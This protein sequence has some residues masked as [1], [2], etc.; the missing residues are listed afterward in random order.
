MNLLKNI[1]VLLITIVF[2]FLIVEGGFKILHIFSDAEVSPTNIKGLPY[3]NTP[4]GWFLRY[5]P[6]SGWVFYKNNSLGMRD[7]EREYDKSYGVKRVVCLGDS[8]MFG[9]EVSF[10][11]MFSRQLEKLLNTEDV[12][13]VEVLNCGTTSYSLREY[14]VYLKEKALKFDPDLIMIGL[15]LNDYVTTFKEDITGNVTGVSVGKKFE[16]GWKLFALKLKRVL[17]YSYFLEYLNNSCKALTPSK[18]E[19]YKQEQFKDVG[20]AIVWERNKK[21]FSQMKDI[22]DAHE[23]PLLV[24]I[25]P[26]AVQLGNYSAEEQPQKVIVSILKS[27]EIDY[28]DLLPVYAVHQQQTG[29]VFSRFDPVHPMPLGH[30][31]AADMVK[32]E[33]QGKNLL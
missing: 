28:V 14:V 12:I 30:K 15:C 11:K 18:K 29:K 20:K 5:Q 23:I 27:L 4:N 8:I 7:V 9:G 16:T 17:F 6:S 10:D 2:L 32:K 24:V 33:I 21:Y 13:D 3:E 26:T 22:C 25:F 19:A 31:I 1:A